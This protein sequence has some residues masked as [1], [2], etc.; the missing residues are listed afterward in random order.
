M[1]IG[2]IVRLTIESM[3][4]SGEG[5][6]HK[7]GYTYF[8]RGAIEGEEVDARITYIKDKLVFCETAKLY[9]L[10]YYRCQPQCVVAT[11]CG[12]CSMQHIEYQKQLLIKAEQIQNCLKKYAGITL[13]KKISV[14]PSE[15]K[16]GYRNKLQLPI[17]EF[18]GKVRLGFFREGSH[19]LVP[20]K[21]CALHKSWADSLIE[22]IS[23][24]IET[25]KVSA[26]D[27]VTGKGLLRHLV[28]RK[29]GNCLAI[30]I[31]IN[32]TRLTRAQELVKMLS[33]VFDNNY[34]LSYSV[35]RTRGNLIMTNNINPIFND[36][37]VKEQLYGLKVEYSPL[38][39]M[40]VNTQV[41][42]EL[43]KDVVEHIEENSVVIDAYSGIGIMTALVSRKAKQVVG[44]EIVADAVANADRI[45]KI[46]GIKNMRNYLGDCVD[47]LPTV[48]TNLREGKDIS[49]LTHNKNEDY[50]KESFDPNC[51]LSIILD[52]PRKG[53][54]RKVL[55]AVMMSNADQVIYVSCNPATLSR[56]LSVLCQKYKIADIKAY[57]MFPM[58]SSIETVV[59][60]SKSNSL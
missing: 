56:D 2:E 25:F 24:Y 15:E 5:I 16:Y 28:A 33:A 49:S 50:K 44:I 55:N 35:N 45:A 10:S 31:V 59:V 9:N 13:D 39:F 41:A 30:I 11:A 38:S 4:A 36:L 43:Y 20:I 54:E 18:K 53:C 32:D 48:I 6:A 34:S 51:Q 12:G 58:T 40:Q 7:D 37:M 23:K 22:V 46:N 52:P 14:I 8:V 21:H 60:L 27:E 19:D 1:L 3:G 42:G 17:R 29:C 57:D 26:Y 47:I